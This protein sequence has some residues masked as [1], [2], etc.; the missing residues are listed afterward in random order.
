M[1]ALRIV[2]LAVMMVAVSA[3]A[4]TAAPSPSERMIDAINAVRADNG[5]R[6]LREAPKLA[7]SSQGYAKHLLRT[8]TF[9]HGSSFRSAGFKTAGEIL[10]YTTGWTAKPRPA[11]RMWMNSSG[12]RGLILNSAFRYI[13]AGVARGRLGSAMATVFVVHFGAH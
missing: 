2:A 1:K 11:I 13:G 10:A 6:P 4:A 7:R 3:P 12:H 9:G 5:L 8:D